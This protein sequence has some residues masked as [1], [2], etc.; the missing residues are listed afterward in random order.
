MG[1]INLQLKLLV[2]LQSTHEV[3]FYQGSSHTLSDETWDFI[4]NED[5]QLKRIGLNA[6]KIIGKIPDST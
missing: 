4:Q 6:R 1:F 2:A 3:R 5:T